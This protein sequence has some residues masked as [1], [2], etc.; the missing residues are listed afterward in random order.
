MIEKF[1]VSPHWNFR[2]KEVAE[3]FDEHV[4]SQLPWYD[5]AL[6]M[7]AHL[8]TS[9]AKEHA[10]IY[11]FG[12]ST[13][14]LENK[15]D[16]LIEKRMLHFKPVDYSEEMKKKYKGRTPLIVEDFRD[17]NIES[18][19]VAV[20]NLSLM[21]LHPIDRNRFLKKLSESMRDRFSTIIVV[22]KFISYNNSY[23][24]QVMYKFTMKNKMK[25]TSADEIL[26]KELSL[27]G[28]QFPI[29]ISEL[30]ELFFCNQVFQVG[31]FRGYVLT[32]KYSIKYF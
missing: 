20:C 9:Y 27:S 30:E 13:G 22:D 26:K 21:F 29:H 5:M 25:S 11:D 7:L 31:N 15:I 17:I 18:F 24:E 23:L 3:N 28:V 4:K 12:A 6:D 19:D 16:E 8:I 10:V 1:G 2:D 32:D 14:N